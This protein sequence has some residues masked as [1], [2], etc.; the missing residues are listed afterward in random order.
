MEGKVIALKRDLFLLFG[1][2]LVAK[3]S[4][5]QRLSWHLELCTYVVVT[6]SNFTAS[7]FRTLKFNLDLSYLIICWIFG[8]VGFVK[9]TAAV[10][11][12]YGGEDR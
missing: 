9:S 3:R 7:F 4:Y 12:L 1:I 11:F 2:F 6:A 8:G 10:F 5:I